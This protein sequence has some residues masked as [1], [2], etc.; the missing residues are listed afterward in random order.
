MNI[1]EEESENMAEHPPMWELQFPDVRVPHFG[2]LGH[3]PAQR[4]SN[5]VFDLEWVLGPIW[6]VH[7]GLFIQTLEGFVVR[8]TILRKQINFQ[9][10]PMVLTWRRER[11]Y[12]C[13]KKVLLCGLRSIRSRSSS[14]LQPKLILH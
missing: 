4:W 14:N 1:E 5:C 9:R 13:C 8:E 3:R 7:R 10:V 12:F 11:N 2:A 6:M